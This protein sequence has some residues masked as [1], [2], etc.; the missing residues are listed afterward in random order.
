MRNANPSTALRNGAPLWDTNGDPIHAHGRHMLHKDGYYYW[1]GENRTG[2][3]KVSCYR[4]ADLIH[5]EWRNDVLTLD[6]PVKPIYH[7]TSLVLEPDGSE[8]RGYGAGAVIER[9][10]VLF[11]PLTGKY[12]MW[13]HWEN[14][15]NYADARCAV[16]TCDT[17]DGD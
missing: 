7:R 13:M 4:S 16:A 14:G 10:K 2:R 3:R 5:W 11:N 17:V 9:P 15:R 6:S 1:F 12:V 8:D